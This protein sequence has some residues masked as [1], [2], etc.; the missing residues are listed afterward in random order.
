MDHFNT[1]P[2]QVAEAAE[3]L[4]MGKPLVHALLERGATV[5]SIKIMSPTKRFSEYCDWHGLVGWSSSLLAAARSAGVK[6]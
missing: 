4:G 6:L 1:T 2:T 3:Q 5:E